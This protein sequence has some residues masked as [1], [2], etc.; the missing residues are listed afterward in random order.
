MQA[1]RKRTYDEANP[2]IPVFANR[3]L[4][5]ENMIAD[6]RNALE[7]AR[8]TGYQGYTYLKSKS[9]KAID[10]ADQ[11]SCASARVIDFLRSDI[12]SRTTITFPFKLADRNAR[13]SFCSAFNNQVNA[14]FDVSLGFPTTTTYFAWLFGNPF[15]ARILA[16]LLITETR[17]GDLNSLLRAS[18]KFNAWFYS[19]NEMYFLPVISRMVAFSDFAHLSFI[20]LSEPLAAT[21]TMREIAAPGLSTDKPVVDLGTAAI[22]ATKAAEA[23]AL[24]RDRYVPSFPLADITRILTNLPADVIEIHRG[25][26]EAFEDFSEITFK[27]TGAKTFVFARDSYEQMDIRVLAAL[28]GNYRVLYHLLR[29]ALVGKPVTELIARQ[30]IVA[31]LASRNYAVHDLVL[32]YVRQNMAVYSD[33][34]PNFAEIHIRI[35]LALQPPPTMFM[36]IALRYDPIQVD[37]IINE[38]ISLRTGLD[39]YFEPVNYL[40]QFK[41]TDTLT[42]KHI[43]TACHDICPDFVLAKLFECQPDHVARVLKTSHPWCD[44]RTW[45]DFAKI[46]T[47]D[48]RRLFN[49]LRNP[50]PPPPRC[51]PLPPKR[52]LGKRPAAKPVPEE[53]IIPSSDDEI[54]DPRDEP[55]VVDDEED[56]E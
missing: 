6:Y 37:S 24:A 20:R 23:A 19:S 55:F 53:I 16:T 47:V 35:A 39:D 7:R 18:R 33:E 30:L 17:W 26:F 50:P 36:S 31:S 41:L 8:H 28:I 14:P 4:E 21:P 52:G 42:V 25:A 56:N 32:E 40:T 29:I 34:V 1:N 27:H 12:A 44:A 9:Q 49:R 13:D 5:F 11:H 10:F 48:K 45:D 15:F 54:D 2:E 46:L 43:K 51:W 22:D 3:P 38:M